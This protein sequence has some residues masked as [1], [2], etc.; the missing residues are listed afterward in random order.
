MD[1]NI[2][3]AK[4]TF[5]AQLICSFI[6]T[7]VQKSVFLMTRLDSFN[8]RHCNIF[9]F[10]VGSISKMVESEFWRMFLCMDPHKSS[11]GVCRISTEVNCL[12]L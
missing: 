2:C 7:Y 11:E 9:M 12:W 1:C 8:G 4:S 3:V 5:A 10:L 6:F